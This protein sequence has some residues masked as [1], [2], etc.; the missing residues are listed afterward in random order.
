MAPSRPAKAI[1]VNV[2][3]LNATKVGRALASEIEVVAKEL[4]VKVDVRD[5]I[6]PSSPMALAI[7][8]LLFGILI[9]N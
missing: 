9:F 8:S 6:E 5:S 2:P 3:R 1:K 7:V 4:H